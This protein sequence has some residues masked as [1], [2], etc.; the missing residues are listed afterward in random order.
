MN[1][2]PNFFDVVR[3]PLGAREYLARDNSRSVAL[4]NGDSRSSVVIARSGN[5]G[6]NLTINT[7][8]K[9]SK[10]YVIKCT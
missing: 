10:E 7:S 8:S 2:D 3:I 6:S 9:S 1:L 5:N 4:S